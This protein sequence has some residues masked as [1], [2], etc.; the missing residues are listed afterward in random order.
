MGGYA[1]D[2][3]KKQGTICEAHT[4]RNTERGDVVASNVD[5]DGS[6]ESP[7]R[8]RCL[9]RRAID[10]ERASAAGSDGRVLSQRGSDMNPVLP[11]NSGALRICDVAIE[12]LS[13][14]CGF[15]CRFKRCS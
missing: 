2:R 15:N 13:I 7:A 14:R 1:P 5:G 6:E 12:T 11:M 10:G 4:Y 3:E 9:A 8:K